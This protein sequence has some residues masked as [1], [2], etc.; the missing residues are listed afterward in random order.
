MRRGVG[1]AVVVASTIVGVTG[2][3][4]DVI[5]AIVGKGNE[6][7][8]VSVSVPI[9]SAVGGAGKARAVVVT[10]LVALAVIVAPV[11]PGV[12]VAET[13]TVVESG[14]V[15]VALADSE[16]ALVDVV[17]AMGSAA[18]GMADNPLDG[19][20]AAPRNRTRNRTRLAGCSRTSM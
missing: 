14:G 11:V 16:A 9:A 12:S 18:G 17:D 2:A 8:V 20:T 3:I 5:G 4:V 10:A 1:D 15:A 19:R 13:A 7:A 6:V